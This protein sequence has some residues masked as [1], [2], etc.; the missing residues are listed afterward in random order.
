MP[1]TS[2][3]ASRRTGLRNITVAYNLRDIDDTVDNAVQPVALQF[4]VGSTGTWTNVPAAF[5]ADATTRPERR[6][7][8]DA[9]QRPSPDRRPMT[10]ALLEIADHHRQRRRYDE[11]VG[12]DD[13]SVTASPMDQPPA[14]TST[15]PADGA[16]DV[17]VDA[18]LSVTFD[19]PVDVSGGW[20]DIKCPSGSHTV[21]VSGGPLTY[22]LDP[23]VDFDNDET[24]RFTVSA[25]TSRT[26]TRTIRRHPG[27]GSRRDLP[28]GRGASAAADS[29]RRRSATPSSSAGASWS[30]PPGR[31]RTADAPT[32]RWDLD[33]DGTFETAGQSVTFSAAGLRCAAD[34]ERSW[35]GRRPRPG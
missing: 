17:A 1:R 16:T 19:E 28:D 22:T 15:F 34:P 4:R 32:Y 30:P 33:D 13:I 31:S 23:A 21:S 18:N 20:Y 9:G 24:C 3:S 2:G 11:W 7:A 29:R 26:R 8:G 10:V 35:C 5:V 25:R 6:D 14:V 12:I 27:R